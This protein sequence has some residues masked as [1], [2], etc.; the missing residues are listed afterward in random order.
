MEPNNTPG[1]FRPPR[2]TADS[3]RPTRE[4]PYGD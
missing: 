1:D 2:P 4:G 3:P